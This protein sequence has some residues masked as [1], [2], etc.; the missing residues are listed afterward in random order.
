MQIWWCNQSRCWDDEYRD[1]VVRASDR[2]ESLTFRETVSE[3]KKGDIIVHYRK[4]FVVA[5]SRAEE[6]GAYKNNL[7]AGYDSGWEFKTTY[8]LFDPPINRSQFADA[9]SR[10]T[11]KHYALAQNGNV[12]QGYFLRFD[13]RGLYEVV[14]YANGTELSLSG[15]GS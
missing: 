11:G 7:P 5:I 15:A 8:F 3:V 2:M 14:K 6:D 4:P 12:K 9:V 1:S 10:F 13:K